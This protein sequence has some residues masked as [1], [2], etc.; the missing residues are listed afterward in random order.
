MNKLQKTRLAVA[1]LAA[2]LTG[3]TLAEPTQ[4]QT[5]SAE[6]KTVMTNALETA[7]DAWERLKTY[8]TPSSGAPQ[9]SRQLIAQADDDELSFKNLM[10]AAGF[11]VKEIETG[12]SVVPYLSMTFGKARE[13]SEPDETNLN[14]L[15]RK[16][17]RAKSGPIAYAERTIVN[18]VL[19]VQMMRGYTLDKVEVDLLPL[20][21][22]KFVATPADAPL[23]E[24]TSRIIRSIE[25][26]NAT[27]SRAAQR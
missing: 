18:A 1:A 25:G 4:A 5:A 3:G 8:F 16:H 20:P 13:L 26:I 11:K 22:V 27:L 19:D 24:E 9:I 12:F 10:D 14:R 15:L 7:D 17:E 23:S 21:K 2:S 6:M